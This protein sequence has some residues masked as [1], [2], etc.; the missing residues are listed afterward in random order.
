M[1][2]LD[3]YRTALLAAHPDVAGERLVAA[4]DERPTEFSRFVVDMGLGPLWHVR[5]GRAEF[6]ES[7]LQA[8]ALYL[9]QETS[10]DEIG[11]ALDAA[12]IEHV[13]IKGAATRLLL[14][15]NPAVRASFDLDL[16][17]RSADRLETAE[18]I[19]R[20]GFTPLPDAKSISRELVLTRSGT[21]VDLHWGLL[22]EGR[23]RTDPTA[24]ILACRRRVGNAWV[25]SSNNML[26]ILL[27]HPAFAKHLAGWGMGLHRVADLLA[28]L[29]TLDFDLPSVLALVRDNGVSTAAWATLRW[30]QLLAEPH[31]P[32]NL[33]ILLA[34]LE[35]PRLKRAW[36]DGWLRNDLSDRLA[37]YHGTRLFAFSWL[38]HDTPADALRALRGRRR[39]LQRSGEDL[40][41]FAGLLGE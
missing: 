32:P 31:V 33:L 9:A 15:D 38:L 18:T 36:L 34:E 6:H 26:F 16:L 19:S 11:A 20:L 3:D 10:L 2:R 41:A 30:I 12:G 14:Y 24:E 13:A 29:R 17:I 21:D 22:R 4:L 35:P 5:T 40:A 7:R 39:A 8:E 23:L 1:S 28:F 25:P 27:V 37:A